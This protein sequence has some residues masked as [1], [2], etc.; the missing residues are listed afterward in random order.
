MAPLSLLVVN[1]NTS[2]SMTAALE[3][4]ISNLKLPNVRYTYFTAPT[5][6]SS[7][8]NDTD[9]LD[10]AT[11]CFP[12]LA[13]LLP[14]HDGILIACYSSHPLVSQLRQKGTETGWNGLVLGIFEASLEVAVG[15]LEQGL[16]DDKDE[17]EKT[18][19]R[20]AFGIVSTG[21]IWEALLTR[22][23]EDWFRSRSTG[24][25]PR[26]I[27]ISHFAG[28]HTT[29][30]NASELHSAPPDLV[31]RRM[32]DATRR[33]LRHEELDVRVVL[34]GCAGMSGLGR[35]VREACV[36]ECGAERGGV[37]GVRVVDA[38]AAGVVV[39][40]EGLRRVAGREQEE[41]R[42]VEVLFEGVRMG[43]LGL[44]GMGTV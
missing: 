23:V 34:L 21:K 16:P 5:G 4:L 12:L 1:P 40:V 26:R 13:S 28:V 43:D 18:G 6:P 15:S 30:L 38:V 27:T 20:K 24:P 10:S 41:G 8:N 39:L 2:T 3:P 29:G 44:G 11:H 32:K 17:E 31:T 33:L 35:I 7:I 14:A 25:I 9:A 37:M 22:G 36:E 19:K 42:G